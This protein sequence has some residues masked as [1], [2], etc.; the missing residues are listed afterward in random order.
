VTDK[1]LDTGA[2]NK[3]PWGQEYT[4][5]CSEDDIVVSS[6]GPD[7]KS[8]SGDDIR[9]PTGVRGGEGE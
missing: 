8:G 2:N 5:A 4:V 1:F 9:V 3:D 7:K 6:A